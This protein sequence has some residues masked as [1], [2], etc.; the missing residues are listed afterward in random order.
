MK[1]LIADQDAAVREIVT[2]LAGDAKLSVETASD[3]AKAWELL[4]SND[5][6]R[7]AVLEWN[8]GEIGG[9]DLCRKVRSLTRPPYT[10][11][12][13]TGA[14]KAELME[15]FDAGADDCMPQPLDQDELAFR[16]RKAL[17]FVQ[18]EEKLLRIIGGWR[19]MLDSLPFGVACLGASGQLLRANRIFDE[20][21]GHDVKTLLG[22]SLHQTVLPNDQY[23][24]RLM[25]S[26]RSSEG[27]DR[28]Q[29][30]MVQYDGTP[31]NLIVWGRP[32]PD[33]KEMV[34]QIITG[35]P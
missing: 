9:Q 23:Y 14:G 34:F 35:L 12:I 32:I 31:R 2:R 5:P 19:T 24:E 27:F 10:Y 3:G 26:I 18:M 20:M 16:V 17:R 1:L 13:L 8:L 4:C 28:I 33:T 22:R 15:A 29:M 21:L 6:P 25:K 11:V 30:E 7:L